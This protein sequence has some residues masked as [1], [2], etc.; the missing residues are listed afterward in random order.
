MSDDLERNEGGWVAPEHTNGA[1]RNAVRNDE[2]AGTQAAGNE[3]G[4]PRQRA[5]YRLRRRFDAS[6]L[7]AT[8]ARTSFGWSGDG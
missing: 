7:S 5:D 1:V 2:P 6:R 4:L 3:L 8:Y